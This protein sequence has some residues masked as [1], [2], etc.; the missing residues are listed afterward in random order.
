MILAN[1]RISLRVRPEVSQ[2]SSVGAVQ[3]NGISIPSLVTRRAETTVELGSG[4][5]FAIGGLLENNSSNNV[6]NLPGLE[7]LPVLG[8]LFRSTQF[9]RN[10]TELVILVTP[11]LVRPVSDGS[12]RVPNAGD[13]APEAGPPIAPDGEHLIGPAGFVVN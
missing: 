3:M 4:D 5:S 13:A 8:A 9:Q 6:N 12:L 7:S 11:Y 10:E 1:G 2:L